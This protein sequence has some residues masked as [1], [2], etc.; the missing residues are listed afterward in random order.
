MKR[1]ISPRTCSYTDEHF[2]ILRLCGHISKRMCG[3]IE[4]S[5]NWVHFSTW[6]T[7]LHGGRTQS[8]VLSAAVAHSGA[9]D[10]R[11]APSSIVLPAP[12]TG[13]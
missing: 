6:S 7:W 1:V 8:M 2:S 5:I 9:P 13:P 10:P 11:P 4:Q 12:R 3:L